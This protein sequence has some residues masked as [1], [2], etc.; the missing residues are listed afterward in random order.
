MYTDFS[1]ASASE[2]LL[3]HKEGGQTHITNDAETVRKLLKRESVLKEMQERMAKVEDICKELKEGN[4]ELKEGNTELKKRNEGL[5]GLY[6]EIK[7]SNKELK[8]SNKELKHG[9]ETLKERNEGLKGLY[10]EIKDSNKELEKR[11]R[12]HD[13]QA[14][15][16]AFIE[17]DLCCLNIRKSLLAFPNGRFKSMNG[18]LKIDPV[19]REE[20]NINTHALLLFP[21]L[22]ICSMESADSRHSTLF[23]AYF[24]VSARE[25]ESWSTHE[26]EDIEVSQL[27]QKHSLLITNGVA[28]EFL[29][30]FKSGF[31]ISQDETSSSETS[32]ARVLAPLVSS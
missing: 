32:Q 14:Q 22:G 3:M 24:G 30:P 1:K 2:N 21:C 29:E 11:L 6:K 31:S 23:E 7:D 8:D 18:G 25:A 17:M 4:N 27:L 9:L 19:T 26:F 28:Q 12:V 16:R 5:E 10:K 15:L 20:R 13:E